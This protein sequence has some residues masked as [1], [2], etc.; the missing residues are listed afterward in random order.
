MSGLSTGD[1]V[2]PD[3]LLNSHGMSSRPE[4]YDDLTGG[5][6]EEAEQVS[7]GQVQRV[8]DTS[9]LGAKYDL[10]G[11]AI[12][13]YEQE[14]KNLY[15]YMASISNFA[16]VE[17][18]KFDD[19][20]NRK[21]ECIFID[22]ITMNPAGSVYLNY[23][24]N[25]KSLSINQTVSSYGITASLHINDNNGLIQSLLAHQSNFYCVI[26]IMEVF[27]HNDEVTTDSNV[28]TMETGIMY[29]P[30]IFEIED[31]KSLSIDGAKDKVYS[32]ELID[33][34]SAT[35]KKVSY[36]NL[37]I[38]NPGFIQSKNFAQ[39]YQHIINFAAEIINL[40]HS[41]RFYID[42]Y[43]YFI[44][45]ITDDI[46]DLIKS[47]I[48]K[49]LS[50]DMTC[51]EL[52]NHIYKHAARE[53]EPPS[54]FNGE[55]V[56]NILL[57]LMLQDE[58]EDISKKY[59]TYFNRD[60]TKQVVM[61]ISFEGQRSIDATLIKRGLY[62]KCILM[63]FELA[64]NSDEPIIY[65][66]I[67][68][69][70]NE[71]GQLTSYEKRIAAMNGLVISPVTDSVDIPPANY[72]VGFG[73][74]NLSLISDNPAGSNNMLVYF[75]WIYEFYKAVFLNNKAAA[76]SEVIGKQLQPS[77]DPHFHKMES[78]KLINGD[79]KIFAKI[80]SNTI[81]LKSIDTI[82]EA[83]Y[84]VGRTL[85]SYIFMNSLFGFKIKGSILRHPGEI[86]KITSSTKD[87]ETDGATSAVGGI[88]G[89]LAGFSLAYITNII[90]TFN[91]NKFIDLIYA[92]RICSINP[93]EEEPKPNDDITSNLE[94]NNNPFETVNDAAGLFGG[95]S[96]EDLT[97]DGIEDLTL[98]S[99]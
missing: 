34:I 31:A 14:G 30:Y 41:K 55:K 17:Y 23:G 75:N 13:E 15:E 8:T 92:S 81:I 11:T 58:F 67:N 57:P 37:L 97:L 20:S 47:V 48:L 74:K 26:N 64:F 33:V 88:E 53:I 42:N 93:S 38:H 21:I 78:Q 90:H 3:K 80:N 12:T 39:L 36:G 83:L 65:E 87:E 59:R 1:S 24:K 84:H 40:A 72:L 49:D 18:I 96:M 61:P 28:S 77:I 16:N 9:N 52:L 54:H 60:L 46:N 91:G 70:L 44:D 10:Q 95:P 45:D 63:P 5:W 2:N 51:Y 68:P 89:A 69:I 66:N 71:E 50:I 4:D 6:F 86:I 25:I 22:K 82:K 19:G 85:K 35:L 79:E 73:W 27:N 29:S 76:F 98:D 43:I 32:I 7:G 94:E 99:I 56:G 62:A